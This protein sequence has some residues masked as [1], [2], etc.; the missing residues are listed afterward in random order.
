M[1]CLKGGG[2][3]WGASEK[4]WSRCTALGSARNLRKSPLNLTGAFLA[5]REGRRLKA[6]QRPPQRLLALVWA[7]LAVAVRHELL[8]WTF[9]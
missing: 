7:R 3:R 2:R 6:A 4:G 1:I 8:P 5:A 9:R